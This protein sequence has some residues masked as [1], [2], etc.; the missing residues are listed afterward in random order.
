M[1]WLHKKNKYKND[2]FVSLFEMIQELYEY[3]VII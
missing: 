3:D 2:E 1:F